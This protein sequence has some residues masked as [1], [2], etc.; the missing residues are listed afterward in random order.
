MTTPKFPCVIL[1]ASSQLSRLLSP[2]A[3]QL[4]SEH[5]L[6]VVL[7]AMSKKNLPSQKSADFDPGDF[8]EVVTLDDNI[9]PRSKS[10]LATGP[11]LYADMERFENEIGISYTDIL[12][13]DRHFG[14]E[15]VTGAD[16]MRSR[17]VAETDFFQKLDVVHRICQF[18][19]DIIEKYNPIAVI[20]SGGSLATSALTSICTGKG[21]PT[22]SLS[23]SRLGALFVWTTGWEMMPVGLKSAYGK[24]LLEMRQTPRSGEPDGASGNSGNDAEIP[25]PP[26]RA[27]AFHKSLASR[28]TVRHLV[29]YLWQGIWTE[30]KSRVRGRSGG[31]G[32][33]VLRDRIIMR[34]RLWRSWRSYFRQPEL[35]NTISEGQRFIFYPLATEPESALMLETQSADNQLTVIDWLAKSLPA[36]WLL[37]VKEHMGQHSPRPKGFLKKIS[38]YPNIRFASPLES[39]E[40]FL[41]RA[42]LVATC[43]GSLGTQA[44]I[45]GMPVL[46]FHDKN[47]ILMMPHVLLATSYS[48]TRRAIARIRSSDIAQL[49]ERRQAGQAYRQAITGIG[50]EISDT[51]LISGA[52]GSQSSISPKDVDT[53]SRH[54]MD[55]LLDE[56]TGSDLKID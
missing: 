4:K 55:S 29:K 20:C 10:E 33:Y 36:G 26:E 19:L 15:F 2:L 42:S 11:D 34:Y 14:I 38:R 40:A 39:A 1:F 7:L 23:V 13:T 45:A 8:K 49:R 24:H 48:E 52:A 21:I 44:A 47:H 56:N 46:T 30:A 6:D 31:Y 22:R 37:V 50:F 9:N 53:I 32:S 28:A 51:A 25:A 27:T 35:I 41:G 43:N 18:H 54:F 3:R 17:L 12:R 16:F 5:G